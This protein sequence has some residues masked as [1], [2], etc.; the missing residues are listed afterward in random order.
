MPLNNLFFPKPA[1][2]AGSAVADQRLTV[3]TDA[4]QFATAFNTSTD[5]VVLD[6]QAADVMVTFDGS[7]PT[8]SNG[9]QLVAGEKYSWSRAAATAA[10]FIRQGA[11]DGTIHASEFQF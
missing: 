2:S 3:S 6:I 4:V 9:H 5:I 10:K 11:S 7:T 1:M 8:S